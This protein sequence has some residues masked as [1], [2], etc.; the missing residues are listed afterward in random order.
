M[1]PKER[2]VFRLL[3][4]PEALSRFER[5][6]RVIF[7]DKKL[8]KQAFIHRSYL[9]E[10]RG[11]NLGSNERMEFLGDA[12]LELVVTNH[13]YETFPN[14]QEGMLTNYRS[15]LVSTVMLSEIS[16]ELRMNEFLLVAEGMKKDWQSYR[17][18]LANT[19]EAFIGAVFLDRGYSTVEAFI[20]SHLLHRIHGIVE[21]K[22]WRDYKSLL[23]EITQREL[24]ITP[25]YVLVDESG[26]D[27]EKF[28]VMEVKVGP[29]LSAR[30]EGKSKID[31]SKDA[32]RRLLMKKG[33][34]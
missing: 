9:N 10:N 19:L 4:K 6:V 16:Q 3:D 8:L 21:K 26:P 31:A 12:V 23:Q 2:I 15:A 7:N 18:I 29:R 11:L 27:N 25:E 30:G 14:E 1:Q 13:L 33:W 32:A 5:E 22:S 24:S 28:F 34:L 20:S 17:R